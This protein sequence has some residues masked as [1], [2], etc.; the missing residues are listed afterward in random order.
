MDEFDQHELIRWLAKR[1]E[2]VSGGTWSKIGAKLGRLGYWEFEDY[3]GPALSRHF[4]T[5]QRGQTG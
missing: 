2:S 1:V 5:L 3:G 4:R